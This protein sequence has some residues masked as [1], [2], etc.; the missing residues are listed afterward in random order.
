M[1]GQALSLRPAWRL[2]PV[3]FFPW[4]RRDPPTAPRSQ[5]LLWVTAAAYPWAAPRVQA[6]HRAWGAEAGAGAGADDLPPG[7]LIAVQLDAR[8]GRMHDWLA[9]K[10]SGAAAPTAATAAPSPSCTRAG[11]PP[12]H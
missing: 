2:D 11:P 9:R 10:V 8:G 6:A 12:A 7:T 4:G 5:H 1:T 3:Q